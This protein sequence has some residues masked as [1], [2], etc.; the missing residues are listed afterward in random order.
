MSSG[1]PVARLVQPVIVRVA[2]MAAL[3]AVIAVTGVLLSTTAVNRL[4][5]DLQ[6][7][8]AANQDVYQDL[9]D[10]SAA[11]ESWTAS[12]QAAA[13]DRF[14]Q[15]LV[16]FPADQQKVR[17]FADGD[18]E[19]ELLVVRQER[20]AEQWLEKYARPVMDGPGGTRPA[21]P[22]VR[23]GATTFDAVRSAHQA[24]SQ[25]F[26]SR[27][28]QARTDASFRL[29]GTVLAVVLLT[30]AAWYV[31][32]R[33]RNRLMREL[34]EPLLALETVVQRM[35]KQDP[36]ARAEERGPK[37]VRAVASALNSFADAQRRAQAVEG[38]IQSELRSLDTARDDFVSNVSHELR[39]P[40]TTISGYLEMIAEEFDGRM[41]PR[42]E[43]ILEATRR[44]VARLKA[45]I[46]DLLALSRAEGRG[47]EMETVDL[48]LLVREAVTDVRITAARRG[49]HVTVTGPD[50]VVP[51]LA[52]RAML[53][54]AFLNVLTNAVKFSHDQD[55]VTVEMSIHAREV[56]VAVTDHGIGIPAAELDRLGT[57]FFRASNAVTNEIAGTGLGLR[58]TQT[59][60]DRHSGDVVIE[61]REGEGT[62]VAIRLRLHGEGVPP[63]MPH[64]I[65]A[66]AEAA[67]RAEESPTAPT[68][69]AVAD[70]AGEGGLPRI[71]PAFPRRR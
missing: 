64:E 38:R 22:R 53:H 31:V 70:D 30:A 66:E 5:D 54:R 68:L 32:S 45:L 48:A 59:I 51:V 18:D 17:R 11:V 67:A 6:P 36:D 43:R 41:E 69:R 28:R 65:V 12:G 7:A 63:P 61:S 20:A 55:D 1:R 8:A 44:N 23:A 37:E 35:S 57:R 2:A 19:L 49:I 42:H 27:V 21:E 62:T 26:D 29:K 15:A 33:A 47:S 56:E 13:A 40:L 3:M 24:T 25:A 52:D 39:T 60:V 50:R 16:R 58:I 14:A 71:V 10:M 9:T 46:D 34:S 4:T